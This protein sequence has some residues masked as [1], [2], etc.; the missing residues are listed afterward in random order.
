MQ[1]WNTRFAALE[2]KHLRSPTFAHPMAFEPMALLNFAIK[3]G[4]TSELIDAPFVGKWL[5]SAD[6]IHQDPM[7]K[8]LPSS[9]LFQDFCASIEAKLDHTW[10]SGMATTVCKD[11]ATG[12][13]RV[14]Y[15][16]RAGGR[17]RKV[18][19]SAVI[20]ATGPVG[21]WNVPKPFA[22]HVHSKCILHTEE[23]TAEA[24]GTLREEC[25]RRCGSFTGRVLVIGGGISAAQAAL[26]AYHAGHQV[27]LR[28]RQPLR[29]S[30]FDVGSEWLNSCAIS[31]HLALSPHTSLDPHITRSISD[32]LSDLSVSRA[33]SHASIRPWPSLTSSG[34]CSPL[35]SSA[36]ASQRAA[37]LRVPQSADG[38]A[39]RGR[40]RGHG[41]GLRAGEVYG[42]APPPL[43]GLERAAAGS[44][45]GD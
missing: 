5:A 12:K 41:G 16:A 39:A 10:L 14:H 26:A 28:S 18:M 32:S 19:A 38:Q 24:T 17:D 4:R 22:P 2:I 43:R 7:L 21:K 13:F 23:M 27:V 34:V 8:A 9:A 35:L 42:R 20:L 40:A 30:A 29:V 44:R 37:A 1:A 15:E 33:I 3:A 45:S 11:A 6:L 36:Q 25:S 31:P